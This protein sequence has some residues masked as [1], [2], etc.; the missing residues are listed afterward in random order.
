LKRF[1]SAGFAFVEQ[2]PAQART[3]INVV[4]G[5]DDEFKQRVYQAYNRLFA[6]IIQDIVGAGIAGGD[7]RP[8]DPDMTAALLMT[9]YLGSCSQL[10]ADGKIW[11]GPD[12]V[13]TFI[14]GG[15]RG[16]DHL[17]EGEG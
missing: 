7:F 3:I 13:V 14:L 8:V 1:F 17:S 12:Q 10:D 5:P 9:I 16:Q 6:L 11:L 2:H 15:L 4:Y